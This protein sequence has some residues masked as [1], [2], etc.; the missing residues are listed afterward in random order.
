MGDFDAIR[1]QDSA[2]H[3][4][5]GVFAGGNLVELVDPTTDPYGELAC[6]RVQAE[7]GLRCEALL[8]CPQHLDRSAVDCLICVP[9]D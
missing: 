6:A 4:P 3:M 2:S 7:T 8:L 9:E 5:L 1:H